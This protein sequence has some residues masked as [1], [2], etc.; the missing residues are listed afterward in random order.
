MDGVVE[1]AEAPHEQMKPAEPR[2]SSRHTKGMAPE[3][4]IAVGQHAHLDKPMDI[5][6]ATVLA[7]VPKTDHDFEPTTYAEAIACSQSEA[8]LKS[9]QN[10]FDS[11]TD[12]GTW[13]ITMR[14][15]SRNIIKCKWVYKIKRGAGNQ[16]MKFKSRIVAKGFSQ[17]PNIDFKGTFAPVIKQVTLRTIFAIATA[18]DLDIHH[19]D[20]STAYLNASLEEDIYMELPPG[21]TLKERGD[22]VCK[23]LKSLYGLKQSGQNWSKELASFLQ[24]LKFSRSRADPCLWFRLM[25]DGTFLIILVY[26]DDII[27]VGKKIWIDIFRDAI[28]KEYQMTHDGPINFILGIEVNRDRNK[29][30]LTMTQTAFIH[31]ILKSFGMQDCNVAP[32]PADDSIKLSKQLSPA[33]DEEREEVKNFPFKSLVGSLL[34]ISSSTRPDI[35]QAVNTICKFTDNPGSAHITAGKR[36]LRYLKGTAHYGLQYSNTGVD[37]VGYSDS[38]WAGDKDN[39]RSTSAYI[40]ILSGA[41]VSWASKAQTTVATSTTEAEF[42]ALFF[43]AREAVFL[44]KILSDLNLNPVLP[45]IIFED[46]TG[47]VNLANNP[48]QT[49]GIKHMDIK[50]FFTRELVEMKAIRVI[51]LST[52]LMIADALTKPLMRVKFQEHRPRMLGN[53]FSG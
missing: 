41:A 10:E 2:R 32:T 30:T 51:H 28:S 37:L 52:Q 24:R 45:T 5:A 12:K 15:K 50:Y 48:M 4:L 39:A 40:F 44:G 20:V 21:I 11:H 17:V 19:S 16:V 27:Q 3:R 23:L 14:P 9:M 47:A 35:A 31:S 26:V 34:Y 33:T 22:F 43:A 49:S 53:S 18:Q 7:A 13:E 29:R 1:D 8:W 25:D 38:D 42:I 6:F 46:N 36:I